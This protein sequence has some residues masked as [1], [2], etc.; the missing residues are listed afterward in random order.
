[1]AL[2]KNTETKTERKQTNKNITKLKV[3]FVHDTGQGLQFSHL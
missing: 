1:M 2:V 3:D